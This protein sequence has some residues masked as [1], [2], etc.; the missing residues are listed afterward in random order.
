MADLRVS[1]KHKR[2]VIQDRDQNRIQIGKPFFT[3]TE[4]KKAC[5]VLIKQEAA[6]EVIV[7]KRIKF[8]EAYQQYANKRVEDAERIG[9]RLSRL[10]VVSYVSYWKNY[11][12]KNFPDVYMDEVTGKTLR[13]FIERCYNWHAGFKLE[14]PITYKTAKNLINGIKTFVR[15]AAGEDQTKYVSALYWKL[16]KQEDLKPEDD[17]DYFPTKTTVINPWQ[18]KKLAKILL[19]KKDQDFNSSYKYILCL[20][21]SFLGLRLSEMLGLK[22]EHLDLKRGVL[23]VLGKWDYKEGRWINKT[24]NAASKRPLLLDPRLVEALQWWL[25]KTK[26]MRNIYL[27]PACRGDNPISVHKLRKMFWDIYVEAGLAKVEKITRGKSTHYKIVWSAFKGCPTKTYRHH[28]ATALMNAMKADPRLDKNYVKQ[29]LGHSEF[30]T[31]EGIYGNHN[32][33]L[34]SE[35]EEQKRIAQSK[36]LK[37]LEN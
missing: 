26:D 31:T 21:F 34:T 15:D 18:I 28:L 35:E 20:A 30:A 33:D 11:I 12:S 19:D 29:I 3:K 9:T 8:K 7:S 5:K 1:K 25:G 22:K 23:Q 10:S 17:D 16:H 6:G 2:W 13:L 27:F 24:K 14:E 37:F 4:A 36:A 32:F